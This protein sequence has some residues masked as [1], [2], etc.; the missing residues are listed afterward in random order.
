MNMPAGRKV[1]NAPERPD[2]Q[3]GP[4]RTATDELLRALRRHV[5]EIPADKIVRHERGRYWTDTESGEELEIIRAFVDPVSPDDASCV[6]FTVRDGLIVPFKLRDDEGRTKSTH[7]G[8]MGGR[9]VAG[10]GR[11]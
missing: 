10:R 7:V 8:D 6:A 9:V 11:P 4:L 2:A 1:E 5:R 3:F